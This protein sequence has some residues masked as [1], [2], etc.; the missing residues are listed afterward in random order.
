MP[1]R[2]PADSPARGS[3]T[4]THPLQRPP[5]EQ[6]GASWSMVHT[7]TYG[8]LALPTLIS[9]A[10]W[11]KL[12]AWQGFLVQA[13]LTHTALAATFL[14]G[15]HWGV[16]M[17]YMATDARMPAFHFLWGPVPGYVA[18]LLLMLGERW[19][20]SGMLVLAMCAHWVDQRTLPGCGLGPW[21]PLRRT[22]TG[23]T[24]VYGAI[25]LLALI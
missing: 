15:L 14:G 5:L 10:L 1:A 19:A 13:L 4:A 6:A 3:S 2:T 25:A 20:L 11:L 16:A 24:L 17:R 12:P 22:F 18:W 9:M 7:V 8:S 23:G 21:M